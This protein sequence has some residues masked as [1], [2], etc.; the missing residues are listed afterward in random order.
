MFKWNRYYIA[1]LTLGLVYLFL[2]THN[3]NIDSWYYAACVK[4]NT[5]LWNSHH[6]LYNGFG[7]LW[8]LILQFFYPKIEAIAALNIM[9]SIAAL[10]CLFVLKACL[11]KLNTEKQTAFWL[12]L[13]CGVSFGFM[14]F[15]TDAETYILPLLFSLIAT[16]Y[17]INF[18]NWKQLILAS[19][20]SCLAILFHQL[21]IWWGLAFIISLLLQKPLNIKNI[22]RFS[23]VFILVPI[24]YF[25]IFKIAFSNIT[26]LQFIT[27]EYSK[28]NAGLEFSFKNILFTAIN[29]FRSFMQIHGN[30][31]DFIPSDILFV[32]LLTI[33][34]LLF[35]Y[36]ILKLKPWKTVLKTTNPYKLLFV[37]AF[38]PHIIFAF[39]SSANAEF[40]VMLP[41]LFILYLGCSFQFTNLRF[42]KIIVF[43][44]F[45]WNLGFGILPQRFLI[46]NKMNQQVEITLNHPE[47]Y[48]LWQNKPLVENIIT[49]KKGFNLHHHYIDTRNEKFHLSVDSLIEANQSVFMDDLVNPLG[50]RADFYSDKY[51]LNLKNYE[52][53]VI[54]SYKSF[55]GNNEIYL[56]TKKRE[57]K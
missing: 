40:M 53:K 29:F 26:F 17:F 11:I 16:Y 35:Y 45:I 31:L 34:V 22:L 28:G 38:T 42:L 4:H 32:L 25:F 5:E 9:N 37:L 48:F 3:A 2:P 1:F 47:A 36:L 8:Y 41:L 46:L 51:E 44:L 18:T 6:L 14:R 12:T 23:S 30:I 33:M 10:V 13:L 54:T 19:F 57:F 50:R 15:A 21:H 20:F 27:G 24:M 52:L 55:Y 7:R 39:L 49:Y 56:I 43:V